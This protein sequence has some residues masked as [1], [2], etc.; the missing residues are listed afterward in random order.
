M[1]FIFLL[2]IN[3]TYSSYGLAAEAEK[4]LVF[5][6]LPVI[7]AEKMIKRFGPM[8]DYLS[9][10]IGKDIS[11]E[12][13]PNYKIFVQRTNQEKRYDILFTAPHFYYLAERKVGYEVIVRVSAPTMR[14][15]IV[16][17]KNSPIQSVKELRGKNISLADK[18]S[19][20]T[21]MLR[22]YLLQNDINPDTDVNLIVTP[23]H[24][25]SLLSAY[26][27]ITDAASLMIPPYN[28]AKPEIRDNTRI[29]AKTK[30]TPHMPISVAPWINEQMKIKIQAALLKLNE[31]PEGKKLLRRMSWPGFKKSSPK[32][33][34]G[35]AWAAKQVKID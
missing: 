35:L 21:A 26:K 4:S 28:R 27:G 19:L 20:A 23:N 1:W 11:F 29:L 14:S 22:D 32:E 2:A 31:S 8:I 34:S 24:S 13:A 7:S 9:Q 5:G 6:F 15:V 25:A 18:H 10:E 17:P 30:G 12:S 3:G 33:Y 16:V